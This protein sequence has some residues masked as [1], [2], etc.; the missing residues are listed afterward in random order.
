MQHPIPSCVQS[1]QTMGKRRN[2][3]G[4]PN[5]LEQRFFSTLFWWEKAYM[6]DWIWN[7]A[8]EKGV[9]DLVIDILHNTVV[10][11][12]LEIK[13][14]V[15]QL[16]GLR[17]T[18]VKTLTRNDFP[19]DF[20]VDAKFTIFISQ[21]HKA[22]RLFSCKATLTDKEGR[23]YEGKTY[24]EKAYEMSSKVFQVSLID[25]IRGVFRK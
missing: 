20:I 3:N 24:T 10:P 21:Q 8:N 19:P 14:F 18:I 4:L 25:R 23:V 16:A 9:K 12:E 6:A 11:R 7:A 15:A 22:L 1:N 13:P 17:D 2:L 5:T